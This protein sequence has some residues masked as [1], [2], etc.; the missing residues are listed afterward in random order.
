[1]SK[2][3][4]DS[5]VSLFYQLL[6]EDGT[7]VE[8]NLGE[9]ALTLDMG[10]GTLTQGMEMALIG[11]SAGDSIEVLLTPEQGYGYANEENVHNMPLSDFPADLVPEAGQVIAFDGPD[12]EEII[13]TIIEIKGDDVSVDFGHPLAGRNFIFKAD[14]VKVNRS[15]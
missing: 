7:E 15:N 3:Q 4:T 10:D 1:M 14:I 11:H 2:I 13:G 5:R 6:L 8:S 9:E 12:E